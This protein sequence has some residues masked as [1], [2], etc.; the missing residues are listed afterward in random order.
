MVKIIIGV[1]IAAVIVIAGFMVLQPN[2]TGSES[3]APTTL[4][5]SPNTLKVSIEGEVENEGAFTLEEGSTMLDLIN[6][7]G[8]TT[9]NADAR[10]YYEEV[11]VQKGMTYYIPGVFNEKDVCNN[12]EITKVNINTDDAETLMSI[13]GISASVASS[14][15]SYRQNDTYFQTLEDLL[16]VYGIGNATY[17]KVRDYVILHE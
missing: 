12:E 3:S 4:S 8:G 17:R 5:E 16:N 13:N 11:I 2:L 6:A 10:A 7:A 15:V 9:S 1:I 14:I